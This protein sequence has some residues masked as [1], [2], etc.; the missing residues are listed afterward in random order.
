MKTGYRILGLVIALLLL[1][2]FVYFC[3]HSF[4]GRALA[5]LYEPRV[6]GA[7][8]VATCLYGLVVPVSALAWRKLLRS[9]PDRL[10]WQE[11]CGIMG[12]TQLA[13]YLPGNVAQHAA[14]S[15]LAMARGMTFRAFA[16]SV[17]METALAALACVVVGVLGMAFAGGNVE[18]PPPMAHWL[19]W[20][21]L[22]LV[23]AMVVAPD[24]ART[25][26]RSVGNSRIGKFVSHWEGDI[27]GRAAQI[28][29]FL[30]YC[31]NYLVIG[32][33]L[34]VVASSLGLDARHSYGQLTAVFA[35]SWLAG[36]IAPGLPAGIGVR[37]GVMAMMLGGASASGEVLGTI[38]AMRVATVAA[39]LGWFFLGGWFLARVA[40][41]KNHE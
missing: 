29:A 23:A 1:A 16:T 34:Y 19:P 32:L 7:M 20:L 24:L 5:M 6:I 8:A 18:L 39:D 30:S 38:L 40:A 12:F 35:I 2:Y 28:F 25:L 17:T 15:M 9:K 33:G 31:V 10:G 13:K 22:A 41:R 3:I 21:A 27:P 14:R 4:D 26:L 36:F 37:E 11:L